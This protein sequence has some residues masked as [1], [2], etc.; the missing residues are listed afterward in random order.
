M[1]LVEPGAAL[2]PG[3]M[4]LAP[5]DAS[6]W[7]R[8]AHDISPITHGA[9]MQTLPSLSCAHSCTAFV[10]PP[11]INRGSPRQ[12]RSSDN[13]LRVSFISKTDSLFCDALCVSTGF[14]FE[15]IV[16]HLINAHL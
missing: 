2:M 11:Y 6:V 3:S 9:L 10:I 15:A 8:T 1:G 4:T 7:V 12:A 5:S 16:K 14:L 13:R